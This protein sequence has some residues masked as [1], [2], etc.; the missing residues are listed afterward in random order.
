MEAFAAAYRARFDAEPDAFA[1]GQY[2]AMRMA[3]TATADG[4]A[5]PKALRDKLATTEYRGLA[6][7][8]KSDG[9]GNMAHDA[10][11]VCYDGESRIPH[12]AARYKNVDG[13]H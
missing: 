1:L 5:T 6:M 4:A 12:I 8:Y 2:D 9:T 3:L 10:V 11:I 13:A 7:T